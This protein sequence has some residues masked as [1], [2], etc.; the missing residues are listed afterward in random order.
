METKFPSGNGM[1]T[2]ARRVSML[3][4]HS[5]TQFGGPLVD[6][7]LANLI[8]ERRRRRLE[9]AGAPY[10]EAPRSVQQPGARRLSVAETLRQI[11]QARAQLTAAG[12]PR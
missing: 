1:R 10:Y 2:I 4:Q 8:R 12:E 9:A 5:G 7:R 6:L 11:R 3:E